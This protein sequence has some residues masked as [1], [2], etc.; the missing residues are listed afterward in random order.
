M[1]LKA[2][3]GDD[4]NGLFAYVLRQ[5]RHSHLG[6][7]RVIMMDGVY[8][9]RTAAAEMTRNA[10]LAP[11]RTRPVVHLMA[12]AE[13]GLTEEQYHSLAPRMIKAA[14][15][16]GRAFVA[17]VH[18][19]GHLHV[20]ACEMDDEGQPPARWLWHG[21][22]KREVDAA[23]AQSLPRGAV[24]SRA[25]DSHMA[26]R[27][28]NLARTLEDEWDLIRLSSSPKTRD[29][30]P[31]IDRWQ[32]ERLERSAEV[33]LQDRY[34][35]Q[36]RTALAFRNWD[37]RVAAL[38]H[39]GLAIR[40]HR[41]G[42]R[43]RG[44]QIHSLSNADEFV[45]ISAFDMGGMAKLDATADQSFLAWE[46]ARRAAKVSLR[47]INLA[48]PEATFDPEMA[49]VR[50]A[51]RDDLRA[52]HVSR[53]RRNKAFAQ[54]KRDKAMMA[55]DLYEFERAMSP[56]L[57]VKGLRAARRE[58]RQGMELR[59]RAA[60]QYELTLAGIDRPRPVFL[61]FVKAEAGRGDAGAARIYR[62]I[63]AGI[64]ES[65]RREHDRKVAALAIA[66]RD[67]RARADD[68]LAMLRELG[69]KLQSAAV[70]FAKRT[71]QQRESMVA[72]TIDAA[73]RAED[74]AKV[75]AMAL[76]SR[77]NAAAHRVR[78][79]RMGRINIDRWKASPE[80]R[81]LVELPAHRSIFLAGAETQTGEIATLSRE[82]LVRGAVQLAE[83]GLHLDPSRLPQHI[84]PLARWAREPEVATALATAH[85]I[86]D[87]AAT[88]RAHEL[89]IRQKNDA[90]MAAQLRVRQ[91]ADGLRTAL[92]AS[93]TRNPTVR[94]TE[95]RAGKAKPVL[96]VAEQQDPGTMPPGGDADRHRLL[97]AIRFGVDDSAATKAYLGAWTDALNGR[98]P[99]LLIEARDLVLI[100]VEAAGIAIRGGFSADAVQRVVAARSPLGSDGAE[101]VEAALRDPATRQAHDDHL[102]EQDRRDTIGWL[103]GRQSLTPVGDRFVDL[104][105]SVLS[106][107]AVDAS[108]LPADRNRSIDHEVAKILV[109]EVDYLQQLQD[110]VAGMSPVA[111]GLGSWD[112]AIYVDTLM[113]DIADTLPADDPRRARVP[114]SRLLSRTA[115]VDIDDRVGVELPGSLPDMPPG[116][117][118]VVGRSGAGGRTMVEGVPVYLGK[119]PIRDVPS[120]LFDADGKPGDRLTALIDMV[121]QSRSQF[122]FENGRLVRFGISA[123]AQRELDRISRDERAQRLI[124][125]TWRATSQTSSALA[126]GDGVGR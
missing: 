8:D 122:A 83:D 113:E 49:R 39:H 15:L 34:R 116:L 104:W 42:D 118:D 126:R 50:A 46:T 48:K 52:W 93:P 9:E 57:T 64:T 13:R 45:K 103:Q 111:R 100:D 54:Y 110:V 82:V 125:A 6:D 77:L 66:V 58:K 84:L 88:R 31:V 99:D 17:V 79:D 117:D 32:R 114:A 40:A 56:L 106:E 76:F 28:T 115:T 107:R 96:V 109:G 44:L 78:V 12:R 94:A 16:E 21:A 101:L 92:A 22:G 59:A 41:V 53:G 105:G 124:E 119:L 43:V 70:D 120:E 112:R 86:E 33:P 97:T 19:D 67:L 25:W 108:V 81:A 121:R 26:W 65:H 68:T 71:D 1:I 63:V 102:E 55:V 18:D 3:R 10:A 38:A 36:V 4:F 98:S 5:G 24:R 95:T 11:S 7:A 27:L 37:D 85:R 23:E 30:S 14:R 69:G 35:E 61:D 2:T 60:L 73:R 62:D 72:A 29:E 123:E 75:L 74:R 91:M 89:M 20:I 90:E 87:A 51:F 47:K 80:E